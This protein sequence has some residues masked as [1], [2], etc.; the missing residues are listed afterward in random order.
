MHQGK[1]KLKTLLAVDDIIL[2][3]NL[4]AQNLYQQC[5]CWRIYAWGNYILRVT[6]WNE[7]KKND[8]N[9]TLAIHILI[10]NY[11]E[12]QII[13]SQPYVSF[14]FLLADGK[15]SWPFL[16]QVHL[17]KQ[18]LEDFTAVLNNTQTYLWPSSEGTRRGCRALF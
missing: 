15:A 3:N 4:L 11:M 17:T 9:K 13:N 5:D 18:S 6:M 7:I 14:T 12:N 8:D 1:T 10:L 16:G 2:F